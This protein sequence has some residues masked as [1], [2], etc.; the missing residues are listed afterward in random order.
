MRLLSE[1]QSLQQIDAEQAYEAWMSNR[2]HVVAHRYGMRWVRSRGHDYLLRL[3]DATGNGRSLGAR[4]AETERIFAE[5]QTAKERA[6]TRDKTLSQTLALHARMNKALRIGRAPQVV[7]KILRAIDVRADGLFRVVGT[8]AL[9]AYEAMAGA[10][11][12]SEL[13]ASGDVDLLGDGRRNVAILAEKLQPEG[14][15]G[16]LR[17]V[18]KTFEPIAAGS[19]RAANAEGFMVDLLIPPRDM[20]EGQPVTAQGGDLVAIEVP[21]LQWLLNVPQ[22]RVIAIAADGFPFALRVPDPR[23]FCLHKA[24]LAKQTDRDPIKKGRDLAQALAL[25]EIILERLPQYPFDDAFLRGLPKP[26]REQ[27]S[28]LGQEPAQP[29]RAAR[30]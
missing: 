23:V 12:V 28:A 4:S 5:F 11:M 8:H 13:L 20:R 24:W 7:G 22:I 18:D 30:T 21:G 27:F 16:I 1:K 25:A 2:R 19:Y 14:L 9:F 17:Q 3:R 6:D 10:H 26:L 15:I 29:R